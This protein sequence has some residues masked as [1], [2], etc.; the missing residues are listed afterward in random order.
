MF[1][2]KPPSLSRRRSLDEM[3]QSLEYL[4]R[5]RAEFERSL[6]ENPGMLDDL[7]PLENEMYALALHT[8][9]EAFSEAMQMDDADFGLESETD[10]YALNKATKFERRVRER[11]G[12]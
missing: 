12:I 3:E 1:G 7:D 9:W 2:L 5:R 6:A 8:L 10:A 11:F 4:K